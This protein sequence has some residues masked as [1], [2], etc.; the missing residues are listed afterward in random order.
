MMRTR[1]GG[2]SFAP[3]GKGDTYS[4]CAPTPLVAE[5]SRKVMHLLWCKGR[6][7]WLVPRCQRSF[8]ALRDLGHLM[9]WVEAAFL[10]SPWISTFNVVCLQS[11]GLRMECW[12]PPYCSFWLAGGN[13]RTMIGIHLP[14]GLGQVY[15]GVS[16]RVSL[17]PFC[18]QP[19]GPEGS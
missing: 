18:S 12:I 17:D 16:E 1:T 8:T 9:T 19:G 4:S 3:F 2:H 7:H 13:S 15:C 14:S 5:N 11:G 10:A 6:W